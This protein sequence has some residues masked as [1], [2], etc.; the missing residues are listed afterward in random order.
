MARQLR[1][2]T[3]ANISKYGGTAQKCMLNYIKLCRTH[4]V[5]WIGDGIVDDD[6]GAVSRRNL[7]G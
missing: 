1:L 3:F 5:V 4:L 6:F 7:T 2:K